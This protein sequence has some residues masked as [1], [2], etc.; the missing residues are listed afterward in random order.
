MELAG[1]LRVL[2]YALAF[3]YLVKWKKVLWILYNLYER[4]SVMKDEIMVDIQQVLS[5]IH[6]Y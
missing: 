6:I 1:G 5:L 4:Q 3:F 2:Y